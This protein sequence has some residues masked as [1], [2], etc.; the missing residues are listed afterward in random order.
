[1]DQ[2][3]MMDILGKAFSAGDFDAL[4][5]LLAEDCEYSPPY[6]SEIIK[7]AAEVLSN[8]KVTHADMDKT[9]AYTYKIIKSE[10][11]LRSGMPLADLDNKPEMHPCKYAL[12]LYRYSPDKPVA[13]VT[14]LLDRLYEKFLC[15]F[16]LR[17]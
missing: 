5:P 2:F 15:I 7:G 9:C 14:C 3:N 10:L 1:M 12:L 16:V 8:M 11:V 6:T 4:R 17:Q 13:V